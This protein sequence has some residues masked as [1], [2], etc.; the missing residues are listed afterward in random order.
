MT[1]KNSTSL[2][3][4][5]TFVVLAVGIISML[6][7]FVQFRMNNPSI[8]SKASTKGHNGQK[9][10][11]NMGAQIG[12]LMQRLE[13][14]PD[15]IKVLEKLGKTFM[16]MQSWDRAI[17][18]WNRALGVDP[19]NIS[20]RMQLAQCLYQKKNYSRAAKHLEEIVRSAPSHTRAHFNL[21]ILYKYYLNA[22]Q[23]WEK[24]FRKVIQS[25]GVEK[26]VRER[27]KKELENDRNK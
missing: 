19:G 1:L 4:K 17:H 7:F 11:E 2:A 20:A 18:F 15:D 25:E 26:S 24:H 14:N 9:D 5:I 23:K 8:A 16:M 21:G 27:A 6:V 13:K 3:N 22:Q 10:M 12:K